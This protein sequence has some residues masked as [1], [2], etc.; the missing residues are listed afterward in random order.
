MSADVQ[1]VVVGGGFAGACAAHVLS[2]Q[3]FSVA[4]VDRHETYPDLFR[5]EKL[6]PDQV[7]IMRKL[8]LLELRAPCTEPIGT[9]LNFDGHALKP[10][11]TVEQYGISYSDTVNRL[12]AALPSTVCRILGRVARI[13][14]G[15]ELP[16]VVLESGTSVSALLVVLAT[17]G[18]EKLLAP[19]GL[20]RRWDRSLKSLSFGFD[21][22]R[23]DGGAWGFNGFNYLLPPNPSRIDY[24][25]VFP[26]GERMRVNLFTQLD[27]KHRLVSS[28][29]TDTLGAMERWFP[30]IGSHVGPI[31]VVSAVQV[32]PTVFYRLKAPA[33]AGL[34]AIGDEYQSVSPTTGTGL[35]RVLN[36]VDA[37]CTRHAPGWLAQGRVSGRAVRAYY[38]DPEK[39]ASDKKALDA[40]FYYHDRQLGGRVPVA[41]RVRRKIM[42]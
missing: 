21:I 41:A 13:E 31:R 2:S 42:R 14:R 23:T 30:G 38:A 19:I 28:F 1:V 11:D 35:S 4:L 7:A 37:L 15:S 10:F 18:S 8:G 3:G 32:V 40:W 26:I 34:V 6:E 17:G 5:A 25:T 24:V 12:V 36:D 22:E 9:T 27:P 20:Q 39:V 33:R 16:R 29:K